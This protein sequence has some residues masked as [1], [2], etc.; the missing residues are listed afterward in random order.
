M[1]FVC[2]DKLFHKNQTFYEIKLFSVDG[3][4]GDLIPRVNLK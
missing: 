4:G 2:M 3:K 1:T